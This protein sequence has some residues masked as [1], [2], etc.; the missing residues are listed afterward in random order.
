MVQEASDA[1]LWQVFMT[2]IFH[3]V[4]KSVLHGLVVWNALRLLTLSI[5]ITV[6]NA[7]FS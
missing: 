5:F 6:T 1:V 7:K 2:D 3:I 4:V